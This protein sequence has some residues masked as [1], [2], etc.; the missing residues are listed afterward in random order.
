MSIVHHLDKVT[1]FLYMHFI[2]AT[3][4][5]SEPLHNLNTIKF[6]CFTLISLSEILNCVRVV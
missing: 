3:D 1:C 5:L 2:P 4:N 6:S